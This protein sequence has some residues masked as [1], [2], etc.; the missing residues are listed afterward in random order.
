[1]TRRNLD[2]PDNEPDE[3][4]DRWGEFH[5]DEASADLSDDIYSV[6]TL[7]E[8][9]KGTHPWDDENRD[10]YCALRTKSLW[11]GSGMIGW[12]LATRQLDGV[13]EAAMSGCP[14]SNIELNHLKGNQ[15]RIDKAKKVIT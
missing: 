13:K 9:W 15:G 12:I 8:D 2:G 3:E 5:T 1:V 11:I 14:K 6:D 4:Y 7:S 10:I